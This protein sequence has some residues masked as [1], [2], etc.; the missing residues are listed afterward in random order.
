MRRPEGSDK[1]SR[2]YLRVSADVSTSEVDSLVCGCG[3]FASSLASFIRALA[4]LI[5]VETSS[6]TERGHLSLM[7]LW[8]RVRIREICRK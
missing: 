7:C 8:H 4:L 2:R 5:R 1:M 6:R 3:S